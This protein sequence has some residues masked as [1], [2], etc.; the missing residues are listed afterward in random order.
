MK[1][2]VKIGILIAGLMGI[3]VPSILAQDKAPSFPGGEEALKQYLKDNTKYPEIAQENGVEGIVEVG[4]IV[5][6]DGKLQ[7]IK[8]IKFI[9][10]DLEKEA[11]RVVS[12]MPAW[13]P[14]EKDG[15]PIEAPASVNVPF[16]LE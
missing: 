8:V 16:L 11:I 6:I 7:N 12:G 9:D 5:M 4:F 10:P 15:S 1:R 13:I 2:I 14:A 3:Y